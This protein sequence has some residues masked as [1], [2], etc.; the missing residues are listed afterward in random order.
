MSSCLL[1]RRQ[2]GWADCDGV[3]VPRPPHPPPQRLPVA[4]L[5][6]QPLGPQEGDLCPL[7]VV[8]EAHSLLPSLL[9]LHD[10]GLAPQLGLPAWQRP[11]EAGGPWFMGALQPGSP[12]LPQASTAS[13]TSKFLRTR[14]AFNPLL[15]PKYPNGP[16]LQLVHNKYYG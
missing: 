15:P 3:Q 5:A 2:V 9:Q 4:S 14:A 16:C 11:A 8:A 1:R 10:R 7:P 13:C 6:Q 12:G